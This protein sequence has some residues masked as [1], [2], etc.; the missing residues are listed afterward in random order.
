MIL[1]RV[2]DDNVVD[3]VQIDFTA[4]VLHELAAEFMID[5]IDQYVLPSRMR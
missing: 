3:V 5:G 4:Q 2:V 1:F